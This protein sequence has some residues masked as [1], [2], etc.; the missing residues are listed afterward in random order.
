MKKIQS[1]VETNNPM[2]M[3]PIDASLK[4]KYEWLVNTFKNIQ[5]H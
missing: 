4:R 5:Y 1:N 2:K 3:I